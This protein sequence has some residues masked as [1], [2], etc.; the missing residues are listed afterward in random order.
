MLDQILNLFEITPDFDLD[1]M[2]EKQGLIDLSANLLVGIKDIF[3]SVSPD[4]VIVQGDTTSALI[5][6][7]AAF[8]SG[9]PLGM[10]K[11]V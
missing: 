10:L 5:A 3:R 8:L 4:A 9:I 7:Q 6:A 11:L 1:I 2:K